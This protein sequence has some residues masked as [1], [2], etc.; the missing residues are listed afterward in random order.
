LDRNMDQI[1]GSLLISF[2]L[3]GTIVGAWAWIMVLF[4]KGVM[5]L[6]GYD[7]IGVRQF[8]GILVYRN[9]NFER[10][11]SQGSYW[12]RAKN[13]QFVRIDTRPEVHRIS[14]SAISLDHFSLNLLYVART[15]I[16]DAKASFESTQNLRDD[17]FVQ[18][19]STVKNVCRLKPRV[20]IQLE[21]EAFG[22]S[23]KDAANLA[24]RNLGCACLTFE[25][26]QADSAGPVADLNDKRMGFGPH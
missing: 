18:L 19:Q 2:L 24:L 16:I 3:I 25:L 4:K 21:Q 11:L 6:I 1:L 5:G 12:I 8:E 15:Q 23:V 7:R 22:A 13:L 9:G 14:Q 17:I 10:T 20:E 26:L